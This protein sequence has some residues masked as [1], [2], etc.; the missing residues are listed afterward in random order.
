MPPAGDRG[1]VLAV[2]APKA[3]AQRLRPLVRRTHAP[4]CSHGQV[5]TANVNR[6]HGDT[7]HHVRSPAARSSATVPPSLWPIRWTGAV[8]SLLEHR[9]EVVDV[10]VEQ[11]GGERRSCVER[12]NPRRSKAMALRPRRHGGKESIPGAGRADAVV[13]PHGRGVTA[14]M[15]LDVHGL[16]PAVYG[17]RDLPDGD[18]HAPEG[19]DGRRELGRGDGP[20]Q[21]DADVDDRDRAGTELNPTTVTACS[22][23]V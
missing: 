1:P 16:R 19:R 21:A 17:R 20:P 23:V 6:N 22:S 2:G 11:C 9:P 8:T 14:R 15:I 13:E 10:V 12:P 5:V 3:A 7:P 4:E 18:A